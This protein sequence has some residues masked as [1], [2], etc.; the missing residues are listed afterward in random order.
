MERELFCYFS[1]DLLSISLNHNQP[2]PAVLIIIGY[3][4]VRMGY[5][6]L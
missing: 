4:I 6:V 5:R 2:L 3:G 1:G